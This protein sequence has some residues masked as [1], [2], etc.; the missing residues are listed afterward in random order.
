MIL[1]RG[2][3]NTKGW[4]MENPSWKICCNPLLHPPPRAWDSPQAAVVPWLCPQ[5]KTQ[6]GPSH[7]T[8]V[9]KIRRRTTSAQHAYDFGGCDEVFTKGQNFVQGQLNGFSGSP[10]YIQISTI[11]CKIKSILP[12]EVT[13]TLYFLKKYDTKQPFSPS[14][15]NWP[16]WYPPKCCICHLFSKW[17]GG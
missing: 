10:R 11:D 3:G 17:E 9:M 15:R 4:S 8:N 14:C 1:K 6:P 7:A 12:G 13:Q 16:K 5:L 2:W